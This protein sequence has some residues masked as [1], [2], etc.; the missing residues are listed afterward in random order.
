[1]DITVPL[2]ALFGVLFT[3]ALEVFHGRDGNSCSDRR[4]NGRSRN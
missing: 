1:M 4:T 2:F 3:L